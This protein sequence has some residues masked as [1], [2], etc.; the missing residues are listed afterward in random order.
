MKGIKARSDDGKIV[1]AIEG[2]EAAGDFLLDLWHADGPL[3]KVMPP[4][5]LCRV[6]GIEAAVVK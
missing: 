6:P 3:A 2:S 4:P 5:G 1:R